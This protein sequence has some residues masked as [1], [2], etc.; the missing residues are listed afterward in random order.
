MMERDSVCKTCFN[1]FV[2]AD[3]STGIPY[4]ASMVRLPDGRYSICPTCHGT[5]FL[6]SIR[7]KEQDGIVEVSIGENQV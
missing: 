6:D 4:L 3:D 2:N 1:R 5:G 7:V